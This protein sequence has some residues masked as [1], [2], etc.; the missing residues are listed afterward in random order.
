MVVSNFVMTQK[1]T[2]LLRSLL[3]RFSALSRTPGCHFNCQSRINPIHITRRFT[4]CHRS[5]NLPSTQGFKVSGGSESGFRF[6]GH[7]SF[8]VSSGGGA[9]GGAGS[10]GGP[11]GGN[12]GGRGGDGG[13]SDWPLLSWYLSL[14]VKYPV[15]TKAVTSA[16]L[17]L[18]GDLIC[19]LVIDQV[20]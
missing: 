1:S 9:G 2:C 8:R 15:M 6:L 16:L 20:C 17:T 5:F 19:Q 18:V 14:L 10:F 4:S 3:F 7:R 13:G 11:G 12:S